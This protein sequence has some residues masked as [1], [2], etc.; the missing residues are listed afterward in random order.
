MRTD[1]KRYE[2]KRN[3]AEIR[4][5]EAEYLYPRSEAKLNSYWM[6]LLYLIYSASRLLTQYQSFKN[7]IYANKLG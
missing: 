4:T 6:A 1:L 3:K 2:A 5:N 7:T